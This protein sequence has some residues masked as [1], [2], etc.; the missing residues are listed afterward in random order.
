MILQHTHDH[1]SPVRDY[2]TTTLTT[3]TTPTVIEVVDTSMLSIQCRLSCPSILSL[4]TRR[5]RAT[6]APT[7]R[8]QQ[9]QQQ[10]KS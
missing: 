3:T 5:E 1:V 10:D 8:Q 6:L 9:Q 7:T 4:P 2:I